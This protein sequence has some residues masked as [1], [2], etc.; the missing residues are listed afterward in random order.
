MG[1]KY[2]FD[3]II[4][5]SG[6]AGNTAAL[7]LAQKSKKRIALVENYAFGGNNLNTRDIPYDISL[8]FSHTFA[9]LSSYPELGGQELRYNFPTVVSHQE[10]TIANLATGNR[11]KLE[12]SRITYISGQAHFINGHTIAVGDKQY[13]ATN[14][15]LAT[16]SKLN[17]G[18]II[19]LDSVNYLTPNTAIKVRRLPKFAFIVGGGPTGCEIAEYFAELGAKVIIMEQ[20]SR[21]LPK[22][23][24]ETSAVITDYFTNELGIMVLTNSKVVAVEQDN[25]SKRVIFNTDH[26]EKAVRVDCIVLA[27]GASPQTDCGLENANVKYTSKGITTNKFLQTSAKNIYAIGD[28]IGNDFSSTEQAEYQAS[29]LAAN[30]LGKTKN[31]ANYKGFVR[32]INTYPTVATV[33]FTEAELGKYKIKCKKSIVYLNELPASKTKRL[34]YGFVKILADRNGHILGA[35]IVAPNAELMAEE[36]SIAIRH[37]IPLL[38]IAGTPHIANSF[39]YAIKLATQKL[40]K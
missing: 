33:G 10:H 16:G 6:P 27:T 23:D 11:Q 5:G 39:N 22:E 37:N 4:I 28:V 1:K 3:Y 7:K 31:S 35:T 12:D 13:T 18:D 40:I 9:R 17:T 25:I 36:F 20:S 19:G 38:T 2:D 26:Q 32:L 21:L 14:F 24:K 29:I 15:I 8:G 34:E 30:L